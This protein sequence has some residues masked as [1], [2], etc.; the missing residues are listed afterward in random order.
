MMNKKLDTLVSA[1]QAGDRD[2]LT[3][4]VREIQDRVHHLAMRMLVNPDDA[5]EA[6]QEILILVITKLSTFR[7]DSA[8]HT[9]V[10]RVATNY[11]LSAKNILERDPGFRSA[12]GAQEG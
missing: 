11:L 12:A 3:G 1:A 7:G 6:T 8:F 5:L 4:V 2:A 9:W 10:Y